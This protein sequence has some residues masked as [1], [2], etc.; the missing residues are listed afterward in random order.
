MEFTPSIDYPCDNFCSKHGQW[1][2]LDDLLDRLLFIAISEE[3]LS[4]SAILID[5]G[6]LIPV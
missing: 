5:L 4:S 3:G 6:P 1:T 2:H